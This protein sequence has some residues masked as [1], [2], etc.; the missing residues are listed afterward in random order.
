MNIGVEL[1]KARKRQGL[2][3]EQLSYDLPVSRESIAKYETGARKLPEDLRRSVAEAV[4]DVEFFFASWQD[5]AG[6]AS[7]PFFNGDYIDRHPASMVFLVRQET[8]EALKHLNEVSWIK[9]IHTRS[10]S[11]K[12][13]MQR[14]LSELLDA[15]ASTIN[16]VAVVSREYGFSLRNI[17]K[18][19][20]LT[21][22]IRKYQK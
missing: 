13:D 9:P 11:E 6:E 19:W 21:L 7:I 4:D 10:Q 20:R 18:Q 1:A 3:Q 16:L 15:A 12:E 17:F 22:K 8:T 14:V 2:T 5:A